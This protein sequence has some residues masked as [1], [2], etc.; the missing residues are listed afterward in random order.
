MGLEVGEITGSFGH[1]SGCAGSRAAGHDL[2][3]TREIASPGVVAFRYMVIRQTETA[4]L[5]TTAAPQCPEASTRRS[6]MASIRLVGPTQPMLLL[7]LLYWG[8]LLKGH[9]LE[10]LGLRP[11]RILVD[12]SSQLTG[13]RQF[14]SFASRL[15]A[16]VS[17]LLRA[18]FSSGASFLPLV[19]LSHCPYCDE[20]HA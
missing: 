15:R 10:A 20:F 6:F 8:C 11:R 3:G 4:A 9:R 14:Q 2:S 1:Q 19:L 16:F 5:D 7:L 12:E 17:S 18:S 13:Q